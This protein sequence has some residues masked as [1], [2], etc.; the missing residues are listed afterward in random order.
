MTVKELIEKLSK[1]NP[2]LECFTV[3]S[4]DH[5]CKFI[6]AMSDGD[7]KGDFAFIEIYS[8]GPAELN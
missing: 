5:W 1:L 4:N 7:D 8:L 2:D 6:D 3:D